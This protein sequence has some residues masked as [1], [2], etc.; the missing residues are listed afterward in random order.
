MVII[1][2]KILVT[3]C[4]KYHTEYNIFQG[5]KHLA[6]GLI[7]GF[8]CLVSGYA[9]GTVAEEGIKTVAQEEKLFVGMVLALIF[10]EALGL[11]GLIVGLIL[12]Q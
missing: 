10:V 2:I 4:G 12:T 1:L 8:C 5:L 7:N 6:S 3:D 9:I 11:Y